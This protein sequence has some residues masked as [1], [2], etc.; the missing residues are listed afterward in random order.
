[1]CCVLPYS[2]HLPHQHH[3]CHQLH[4]I[5]SPHPQGHL[6]KSLYTHFQHQQHSTKS[7]HVQLLCVQ[8]Q[9]LNFL[10]VV[11]HHCSP[12]CVWLRSPSLKPTLAQWDWDDNSDTDEDCMVLKCG[13]PPTAY[14]YH[15]PQSCRKFLQ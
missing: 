2:P 4:P 13:F 8:N 12:C 14:T 1:M 10:Q 15:Y 3:Y 11:V 7:P 9:P 5:Q 6:L